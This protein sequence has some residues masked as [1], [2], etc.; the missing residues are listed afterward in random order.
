MSFRMV[1]C[2]TGYRQASRMKAK[3]AR[4]LEKALTN[5]SHLSD[6]SNLMQQLGNTVHLGQ[7]FDIIKGIT[8]KE[9]ERGSSRPLKGERHRQTQPTVDVLVHI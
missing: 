7:G 4:L 2:Q 5:Q 1:A 8:V 3:N 9:E 6:H